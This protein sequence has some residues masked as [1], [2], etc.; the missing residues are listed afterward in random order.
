MREVLEDGHQHA[1]LRLTPTGADAGNTYTG[2]HEPREPG[3]GAAASRRRV[4]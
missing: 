4:L 1:A 3:E 2:P